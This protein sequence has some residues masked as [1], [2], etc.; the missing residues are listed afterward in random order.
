MKAAVSIDVQAIRADELYRLDDFKAL[1]GLGSHAMR[2]AHRAGLKVTHVGRRAFVRGADFMQYVQALSGD[3]PNAA[4]AK[5][6][7][8]AEA[9]TVMT[10]FHP[11]AEF[12]P[13]DDGRR[14]QGTRGGRQRARPS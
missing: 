9:V 2:S 14:D 11:L 3:S 10:E 1:S 5:P 4:G 7:A 13:H 8:A 6:E 12:V